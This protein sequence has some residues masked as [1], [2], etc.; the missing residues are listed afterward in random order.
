M[1][2]WVEQG[3]FRTS[4]KTQSVP[5]ETEGSSKEIKVLSIYV[6]E[7][8]RKLEQIRQER[9]DSGNRKFGLP[10]SHGGNEG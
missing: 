8:T 3:I 7:D 1:L 10:Q 9:P 6:E 5:L 4:G 2:R